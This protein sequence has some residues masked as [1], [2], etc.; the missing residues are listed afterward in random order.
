MSTS[1]SGG[2]VSW[3]LITASALLARGPVRLWGLVLTDA[4]APT[5]TVYNG[6]NTGGRVVM[7]VRAVGGVQETVSVLL[8]KPLLFSNGLYVDLSGTVDFCLVLFEP[9]PER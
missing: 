2:C 8:T 1:S 9:L 5:A 6:L 4:G 7:G 3:E